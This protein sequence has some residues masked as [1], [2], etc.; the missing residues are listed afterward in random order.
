MISI[1]IP[2][3]NSCAYLPNCLDSIVAQKYTDWECILVDDGS[4]DRSLDICN[5]YAAI[6]SRFRVYHKK[7]GGA[8]SARKYGVEKAIGDWILFS[9]SDDFIPQDALLGLISQDNGHADLIAG[10]IQY[11]NSGVIYKTEKAQGIISKE[12][13]ILYLLE[14]STYI[15]PC[16]KLIRRSLFISLK[17]NID[18][19]IT[20][21]EDLLML[22]T[23]TEEIKNDI[24]VVN[25]GIHYISI[26]RPESASSRSM[27]YGG[28]KALLKSIWGILSEHY[29]GNKEIVT[30]YF[31]FALRILRTMCLNNHIWFQNDKLIDFL[32]SLDRQFQFTIP[33]R[34]KQIILSPIVRFIY[35]IRSYF[36]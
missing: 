14:H 11:E 12:S 22:V 1:V 19:R 17:W 15:G 3:Y 28:C 30:A 8:A 29:L 36:R 26:T 31:S 24:I 16:S 10:T 23:L 25:S 6:D 34:E 18:K 21:F 7:N 2:V 20:N 33:L 9:D 5:E 32:R 13:Y 35:L 27:S 4:A